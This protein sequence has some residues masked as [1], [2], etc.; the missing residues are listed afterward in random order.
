MLKIGDFSRISQVT[1]Q[2]LRYYDDMGLLKPLRVDTFT[3]Y[4][5]YA[6]EQL[7]RLNRILALKDLGF[8]LEQIAQVLDEGL[9]LENLRGMLRLKQG[10]QQQRVREEQER[11]ARVEARLKQIEMEGIMPNYD[12][13]LK[14]I[15]PQPV[16]SLRKVIAK[17]EG[18]GKMFEELFTYL[19]TQGVRPA[20]PPGAI[21]HD[22]EFKEGSLDTEVFVPVTQTFLA[23]NGVQPTQLPGSATMACVIHQGSYE[24]FSGAYGAVMKWVSDN[25][26]R[27]TGPYREFYLRGPSPEATDPNTYVTEIQVAVEKA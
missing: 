21:W 27:V 12:V 8:S 16:A 26:Y 4:R 10:E 23:G 20:G 5:Y 18:V 3:G 22:P 2:A 24:G 14:K 7:P 1:V 13:V 11:L 25:N 6:V 19:G 17:P 15:E 9:S